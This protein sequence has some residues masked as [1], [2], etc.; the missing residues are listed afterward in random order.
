MIGDKYQ[1]NNEFIIHNDIKNSRWNLITDMKKKSDHYIRLQLDNVTFM[2][3]NPIHFLEDNN[4]TAPL[5][6]G[7]IW[8][9]WFTSEDTS[10]MNDPINLINFDNK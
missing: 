6:E 9:G 7:G 8:S 5:Q 2:N 10:C 3:Y 1:D 4:I